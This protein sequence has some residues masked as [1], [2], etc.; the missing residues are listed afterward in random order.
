M[1]V[2]VAPVVLEVLPEAPPFG[3]DGV[4]MRVQ[5]TIV[6]R[7]Q[8]GGRLGR[9]RGRVAVHGVGPHGLHD[10]DHVGLAAVAFFWRPQ[11]DIGRGT[12]GSEH[13]V[14]QLA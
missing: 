11:V 4:E 1:E 2:T 7:V 13:L 6:V 9:S 3:A 10:A 5:R 14:H 8:R 12:D